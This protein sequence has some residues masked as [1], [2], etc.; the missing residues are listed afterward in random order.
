MLRNSEHTLE[1]RDNF[2][3]EVNEPNL[4]RK[5]VVTIKIVCVLSVLIKFVHELF[6]NYQGI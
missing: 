5:G 4:G 6:A 1:H 2:H 3:V